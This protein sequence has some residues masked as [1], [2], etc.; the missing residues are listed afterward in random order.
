MSDILVFDIE[1]QNFFTDEGVGWNNFEALKISVICVYSY[2]QDK[3]INYE[4]HELHEAVELFRNADK[5]VGFS[6]NRYDVPVLNAYFARMKL[7]NPLNL[8]EKDRLDL[9]DEIEFKTGKRI[10]L[11]KLAQANLGTEKSGHGAQAIELYKE[12]KIDELK[13]YCQKDVEI[14]K[15]LYEVYRDKKFFLL[16]KR[17]AEGF[18][19]LDFGSV[20]YEAEI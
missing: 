9:L 11:N 13:S 15:A 10:S 12:G 3:Y 17:D 20:S 6:M 19:R 14:T 7:E 5:I 8:F 18:D 16:P 1:T 2:A 4:E